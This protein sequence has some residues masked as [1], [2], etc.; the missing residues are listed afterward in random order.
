MMK[1]SRNLKRRC[2]TQISRFRVAGGT[3]TVQ[4]GHKHRHTQTHMRAIVRHEYQGKKNRRRRARFD[5]S[6]RLTFPEEVETVRTKS[7]LFTPTSTKHR[8]LPTTRRPIELQS[9]PLSLLRK[10][11]NRARAK[12]RDKEY[13]SVAHR[14][15]SFNLLLLLPERKVRNGRKILLQNAPLIARFRSAAELYTVPRRK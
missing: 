12:K 15:A 9:R 11:N 7:P 3:T 13:R 4:R 2:R 14:I 6:H 10:T 8:A 5:R 1:I